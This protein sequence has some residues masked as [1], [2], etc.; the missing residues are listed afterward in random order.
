LF[1]QYEVQKKALQNCHKIG[2]DD[3][4]KILSILDSICPQSLVKKYD[5]NEVE[6]NVDLIGGKTFR[7]VKNVVD[8][9]LGADSSGKRKRPKTGAG[10]GGEQGSAE[11]IPSAPAA[12]AAAAAATTT[13]PTDGPIA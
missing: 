6:V 8:S 5:S 4:G 1:V 13:A 11:Q 10:A 9:I 2:Q 12:S 7:E 3:L